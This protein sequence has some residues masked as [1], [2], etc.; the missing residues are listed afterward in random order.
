MPG[1][2]VALVRA[3]KA[4]SGLKLSEDRK[5]GA[6]IVHRAMSEPLRQIAANAGHDPAVV[7]TKVA[8]GK[9]DFGFNAATEEYEDLVKAGVI[10]PAKV[11]RSA[12]ENAASAPRC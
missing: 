1:G 2:G 11:V 5:V 6:Q 8:E 7:F 3:M 9:G 4:V 10:D 12:L